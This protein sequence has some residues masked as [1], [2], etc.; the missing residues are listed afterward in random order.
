MATL[1]LRST[2]SLLILCL[3]L[4]LLSTSISLRGIWLP[5][6]L[7]KS[8]GRSHTR[9]ATLGITFSPRNLRIGI[10]FGSMAYNAKCTYY[11]LLL[12]NE[13][14]DI[15][16]RLNSLGYQF[17]ETYWYYH[18]RNI[19]SVG[20]YFD[21]STSKETKEQIKLAL[22]E[23]QHKYDQ[24]ILMTGH[25]Y[26]LG[27]VFFRGTVEFNNVL[28][29]LGSSIVLIFKELLPLLKMVEPFPRIYSCEERYVDGA[30]LKFGSTK[31]PPKIFQIR[32][33]YR[34]LWPL[35]G[36]KNP[37][38]LMDQTYTISQPYKPE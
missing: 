24:R 26:L 5:W 11:S 22:K 9:R 13:L 25:K 20:V 8:G 15:L 2:F 1:R 34:F 10:D 30:A 18:I 38:S 17:Y 12:R 35:F 4:G 23:T 7:M 16:Y 37:L 31:L 3:V 33:L 19:Q 29:N 14:D 6:V 27:K 28:K 32:L 21:P 36:A